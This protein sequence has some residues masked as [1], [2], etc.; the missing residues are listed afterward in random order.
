MLGAVSECFNSF[1]YFP[2]VKGRCRDIYD[3]I[4]WREI[5]K[6]SSEPLQVPYVFADGESDCNVVYVDSK[7]SC[8]GLKVP[9]FIE[10]AIVGQI[11]FAIDAFYCAI[12]KYT[13]RVER[14]FVFSDFGEADNG[15]Y[16]STFRGE[17]LNSILNIGQEVFFKK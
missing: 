6:E 2:D 7:G 8:A 1:V 12:L 10:D 14:L 15:G 16:L 4:L 5:F 3:Y 13:E 17:F 9:F 11:I